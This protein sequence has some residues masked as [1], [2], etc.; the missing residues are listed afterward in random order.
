MNIFRKKEYF[1]ICR[2]CWEPIPVDNFYK[3][4]ANID[5]LQSYCKLCDN[6]LSKEDYQNNLSDRREKRKQWQKDN[7]EKQLGYARRWR[8]KN[9][10]G[11][12]NE[13]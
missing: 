13:K 10:K 11:A 5:G 8:E 1:K 4:K 3:N 12:K 7:Y 6:K 2:H 9:I